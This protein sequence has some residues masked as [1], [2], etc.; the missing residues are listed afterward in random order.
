MIKKYIL[1]DIT[2]D[3]VDRKLLDRPKQGFAVPMTKWLRLYLK[4]EI[5]QLLNKDILKRQGLFE[6]DYMR[7]LAD[8][9]RIS[10]KTIYTDLMWDFYVFERWYREYVEDLWA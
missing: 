7:Y 10:D 5:E 1:K 2:Y 4:D 9:Q 6:Y 3:Y 8:T